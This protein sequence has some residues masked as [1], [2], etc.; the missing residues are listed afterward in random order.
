[1]FCIY[2][3]SSLITIWLRKYSRFIMKLLEQSFQSSCLG[4]GSNRFRTA[5]R[6]KPTQIRFAAFKQFIVYTIV[7][8]CFESFAWRILIRERI[9]YLVE[10]WHFLVSSVTIKDTYPN[11]STSWP[12]NCD[13]A[14]T[15]RRSHMQ[16]S[17]KFI[18][19][20]YVPTTYLYCEQ[21][22]IWPY[23]IVKPFSWLYIWY[24][25][26]HGQTY[27]KLWVNYV[28]LSVHIRRQPHNCIIDKNIEASKRKTNQNRHRY[29][30]ESCWM[31][32]NRTLDLIL[33][34]DR[35]H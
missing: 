8:I 28:Q 1:M 22:R 3:P 34:L 26:A 23:I 15:R 25:Y 19:Q 21:P 4:L 5:I 20:V 35:W 9:P 18:S 14:V 11:L 24:I 17:S 2:L 33:D 7:A 13:F 32:A 30:V 6:F 12:R 10:F 16:D 27:K 31:Y 29:I